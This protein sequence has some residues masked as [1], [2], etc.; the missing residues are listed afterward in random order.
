MADATKATLVLAQLEYVLLLAKMI[1][2]KLAGLPAIKGYGDL[3][4]DFNL[5]FDTSHEAFP[6]SIEAELW[7]NSEVAKAH[8]EALKAVSDVSVRGFRY[9]TNVAEELEKLRP[10]VPPRH[11]DE[12]DKEV[13]DLR[14]NAG[15]LE[16]Y[17]G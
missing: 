2:L 8:M 14:T 4:D 3:V 10:R 5:L 7:D 12:W 17:A 1:E 6:N 9:F 16:K 15:I 11:L 13:R